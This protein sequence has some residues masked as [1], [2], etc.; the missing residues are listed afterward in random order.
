[1]PV[2]IIKALSNLFVREG[3]RN[4]ERIQNDTFS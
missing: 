3:L 2:A 1:M 4:H